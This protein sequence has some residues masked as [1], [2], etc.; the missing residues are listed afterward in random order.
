MFQKSIEVQMNHK[1]VGDF[2]CIVEDIMVDMIARRAKR[3]MGNHRGKAVP[4]L[5]LTDDSENAV[6][7][8]NRMVIEQF[9][10]QVKVWSTA[11][12]NHGTD[13]TARALLCKLKAL[14]LNSANRTSAIDALTP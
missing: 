14:K 3:E 8:W 12:Q 11:I 4:I 5:N 1:Y 10:D 7:E 13:C 9:D 6:G 2:W